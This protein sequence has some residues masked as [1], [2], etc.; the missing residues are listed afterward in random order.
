MK[1]LNISINHHKYWSH[2]VLLEILMSLLGLETTI[3]EW[4][5]KVFYIEIFSLLN[6]RR[7]KISQELKTE[8]VTGK[9]KMKR[10]RKSAKN[11]I[12]LVTFSYWVH[13]S[14]S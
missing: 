8:N 5:R 11:M 9:N 13:F 7:K 10:R 14:Q 6:M 2:K 1:I 12:V 3:R 4:I